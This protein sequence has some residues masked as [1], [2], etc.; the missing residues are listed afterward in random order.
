MFLPDGGLPRPAALASLRDGR[1]RPFRPTETRA[2][3]AGKPVRGVH[4]HGS[5]M[6][7][8]SVK[9]LGLALAALA[10]PATA[11]AAQPRPWQ[12]GFQEAATPLMERIDEFHDLLLVV[13]VLISLFVLG[14]LAYVVFRFNE[15]ANPEP[16]RTTHN[17]RLEVL[18]TVI[19]VL[20]LVA[21]AVPS[22]RLLYYSDV[23]PETGMTLQATGNQWYWTYLYP[24]HGD[25]EFDSNMV[26][27][28]DL[29]PGQPR[30]LETDNRVVLPADTA[31]R[32]QVTASDVLH[33]WAIPAFGIKI[34]AV[35]GRLN[36]VWIPPV[37]RTGVYYG[38]CSELCG[39][40]H[41]FMPIAVEVVSKPDFE[42]WVAEAR[43]RFAAGD[44]PARIAR[45]A[46][47]GKARN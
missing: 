16:S 47:N 45:A 8:T 10:A 44:P 3:P 7:P 37:S 17:A 6:M 1:E 15:K 23:V 34:D 2:A 38:Q 29:E 31:V 21:I 13:I 41:G 25:L 30:L 18:W 42:K 24:D 39:T 14:L 4:Q 19:P 12:T 28:A 36:E 26:P 9:T 27:A 5:C 20:I 32:L 11:G 22:F 35:P 43:Q 46:V 33:A 40:N